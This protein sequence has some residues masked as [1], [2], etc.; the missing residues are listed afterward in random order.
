MTHV[1]SAPRQ[2]RGG[3]HPLATSVVVR[4]I[5]PAVEDLQVLLKRDP[6]IVRWALKKMLLLERDPEAGEALRGGLI[7]W[8]K[9]T[10]SDRDWRVIWRVT[11]DQSGRVVVEYVAEV[12]AVG[13][14]SDAE[15]YAEMAD[16]VSTF[17]QTLWPSRHLRCHRAARQGW[18]GTGGNPRAGCSL[19]SARL[20]GAQARPTGRFAGGNGSR[21]V[22]RRG[23]RRVDALDGFPTRWGRVGRP[24]PIG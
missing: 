16:R 17:G 20:A 23:L 9:L 6:Q 13:A 24:E 2:R 21:D 14:R 5:E 11:H 22:P 3:R 19:R 12:W 8:R 4:L 15:V 10:V 1:V 18:G 7:G